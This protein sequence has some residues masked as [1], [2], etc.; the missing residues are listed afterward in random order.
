MGDQILPR[1]GLV[2]REPM[3]V[4]LDRVRSVGAVSGPYQ[5]ILGLQRLV[6]DTGR[7]GRH[8][9]V[10]VLDSLDATVAERLRD[11][12][13]HWVP[14]SLPLHVVHRPPLQD[15]AMAD[16][17]EISVFG[18]GWIRLGAVTTA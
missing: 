14:S 16:V 12:L 13:L 17:G 2:R 6:V 5:R 9:D 10:L 11:E 15:G 3:A 7:S 1:C 4:P 8:R 18:P